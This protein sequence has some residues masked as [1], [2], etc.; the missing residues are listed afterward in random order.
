MDLTIDPG[1]VRQIMEEGR[2]AIVG[3]PRDR[4]TF[5]PDHQVFYE[6]ISLQA[7]P[8]TL[9]KITRLIVKDAGDKKLVWRVP[10]EIEYTKGI[11]CKLYMR[12]AFY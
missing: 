10:P 5:S 11:T 2:K 8:D 12:Y 6:E 9:L 4:H 1:C 3:D 7:Q